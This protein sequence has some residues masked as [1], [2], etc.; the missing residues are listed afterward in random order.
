M[1]KVTIYLPDV[2][3]A[4]VKTAGI[5]VS[6]VCQR[7]LE[8]EIRVMEATKINESE[9]R[10]AAKRLLSEE[11]DETRR[12]RT[13]G[14]ADGRRWVLHWAKPSELR[15]MASQIDRTALEDRIPLYESEGFS[16]YDVDAPFETIREMFQEDEMPRDYGDD[17]S[18]V[19][20]RVRGFSH[21][22]LRQGH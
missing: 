13:N 9:I 4:E 3:A 22:C 14:T 18:C 19:L 20:G 8:Q 6:P 16:N 7:A 10:E 17:A 21:G 5:S 12:A 15:R 2:L 1:P 11:A